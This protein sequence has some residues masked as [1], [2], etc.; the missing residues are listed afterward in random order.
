MKMNPKEIQSIKVSIVVPV[1][2]SAP[3]LDKLIQ[4]IQAQTHHNIE[5]I[6]VEDGSPDNSG[7]I[8]DRYA[9]QDPRIIVI[10]QPNK[11]CCEA[12]N[13]GMRHI[14]GDWFTF[15]DGDD[16]IEP[17]CVEYLLR[18]AISMN[19][20]MALTNSVFTTRDRTQNEQEIID[21]W[22]PEVASSKIVQ[23]FGPVGCFNKLYN[24]AMWR[25]SGVTCWQHRHLCRMSSSRAG[26]PS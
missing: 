6:L 19:A 5:A 22:S 7:E 1:Y 11:G 18:L 2:K 23:S 16:W 25:N 4:S 17:D 12:R 21:K 14:T 10:H 15:I 13:E 26:F 24:T 8:C 3:Y 9:A 20:E